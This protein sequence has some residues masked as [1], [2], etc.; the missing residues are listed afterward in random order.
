MYERLENQAVH[1]PAEKHAR[2][3]MR[4]VR[5][6]RGSNGTSIAYARTRLMSEWSDIMSE[7]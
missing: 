3:N 7:A 2:E 4:A 1:L 6:S 5:Q